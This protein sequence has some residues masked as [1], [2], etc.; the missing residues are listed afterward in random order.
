MTNTT[1]TGLCP[2]GNF[3]VE[4]YGT[5]YKWVYSDQPGL[6]YSLMKTHMEFYPN[7]VLRES[8]IHCNATTGF[9]MEDLPYLGFRQYFEGNGLKPDHYGPFLDKVP[10]DQPIIWSKE[11]T[12]L[13]INL[14]L[15]AKNKEH[16]LG[17][18]FAYHL[19]KP[20]EEWEPEM[21]KELEDC[22]SIYKCNAT[23]QLDNVTNENRIEV[24]CVGNA[25]RTT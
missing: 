10:D 13:G 14:N 9:I 1:S 17:R 21:R 7:D 23:I 19:K 18:A 15:N 6:W 3:D 12:G 11:G 20:P 5:E 4:K 16:L 8:I 25:S 24:G 2:N 22:K